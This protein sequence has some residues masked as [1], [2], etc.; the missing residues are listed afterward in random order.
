M[1]EKTTMPFPSNR[2]RYQSRRATTLP[3]NNSVRRTY[4]LLRSTLAELE[5]DAVLVEKDLVDCL[6]ASRNTVRLVL[7]MLAAEGLVCRGPKVGTHVRRSIVIRLDRLVP[8][9][10]IR[11]QEPMHRRL[12]EV[13]LMPAP[14]VVAQ[15]LELPSGSTVRVTE[16]LVMDG[17]TA[18]ALAVSYVGLTTT[19]DATLT[20]PPSDTIAFLEQ[21]LDVDV[22]TADTV[23]VALACDPQTS[24]LLGVPEGSPVLFV[25]DLLRDAE[26]RPLALSQYRFRSNGVMLSVTAW[27]ERA[28]LSAGDTAAGRVVPPAIS[29]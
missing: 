16:G 11:D 4:D 19:Y 22:T 20:E 21:Q 17:T 8:V 6:S 28:R 9:Q 2:A 23:V 27:R 25:E 14:K 3:A 18:V 26:H 29:A 12:L 13:S 15:R 24:T 10:E 5:P 7:Q 1:S